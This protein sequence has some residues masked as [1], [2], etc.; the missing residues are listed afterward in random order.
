MLPEGEQKSTREEMKPAL[1]LKVSRWRLSRRGHSA[2]EDEQVKAE[3]ARG[4]GPPGRGQA[5]PTTR[6]VCTATLGLLKL[7][8]ASAEEARERAETRGWQNAEAHS[9]QDLE[10][11]CLDME[12]A[13]DSQE[14][15]CFQATYRKTA[16]S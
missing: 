4:E 13:H 6:G 14:V 3:Q 9:G 2:T 16:T 15:P 1:K 7:T 11:L 5:E 12:A 10:L 8:F